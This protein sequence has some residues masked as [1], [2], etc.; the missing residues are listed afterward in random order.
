MEEKVVKK[1]LAGQIV[2]YVFL[3]FSFNNKTF[4]PPIVLFALYLFWLLED[5]RQAAWLTLIAVLPF[6][7]G[8]RSWKVDVP[9]PFNL[10]SLGSQP[11]FLHFS[12]SA[13]VLILVFLLITLIFK[14]IKKDKFQLKRADLFLMTFLVLGVFSYLFSLNNP[15]A[16]VSFVGIFQAAILYFLTKYFLVNK[17]I[18]VLTIYC[19]LVLLIFEGLL[20]SGQF[21]LKHPFGRIIE[22]S[23]YASPYG[24]TAIED[25]F[26][27]RATGTFT[28]PNTMAIF[29]LM[30]IPL[31]LSQIIYKFS[32]IKNKLFLSICLIFG[33]LGLV[34][35]FSRAAWAV[36]IVVAIGLA[37]FLIKKKILSFEY[38][39]LFVIIGVVFLILSPLLF[40]RIL[41]LQYSLWGKYSSGKARVQ[42]IQESWEIIKQR[43]ILGIGPG[44]FLPAMVAN[45]LTGVATHFLFPVHNLYLLFASELGLPA[46][47]SFL[48]FLALT[49]KGLLPLRG[50]KR[51]IQGIKL[52]VFSGVIAYLLAVLV[53]TGAGV[54]LEFF[55]LFLGILES[56]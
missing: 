37:R 28:D 50:D 25:V 32:L 45:N 48:V 17:K 34:S 9:L 23:L 56:S 40:Q 13:K 26:Q 33:L 36:F 16:L 29:W 38:K 14:K 22:E 44:N 7:W 19:L 15:L 24:K 4:F 18:F 46:L 1:I 12:L 55:F 20:A 21:L 39:Y 47:V 41:G 3:F 11:P 53:Y 35:T 5:W 6:G 27:F 42:L 43:P 8:L 31:I 49:L 51:E 54:N 10:L 52:G 2:L 30:F